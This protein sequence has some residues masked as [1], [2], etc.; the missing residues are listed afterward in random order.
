MIN[1]VVE[2][3]KLFINAY[4]NLQRSY[5]RLYKT[6][7]N[8]IYIDIESGIM[9]AREIINEQGNTIGIR[10]CNLNTINI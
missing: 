1:Y 9:D 7:I 6:D 10:G 2:D 3:E 4:I 5:A 8:K